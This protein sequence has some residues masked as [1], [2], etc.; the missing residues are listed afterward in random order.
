[1]SHPAQ[2]LPDLRRELATFGVFD[3]LSDEDLLELHSEW[4]SAVAAGVAGSSFGE[5]IAAVL[6]SFEE[7]LSNRITRFTLVMQDVR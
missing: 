3:E 1:M 5:T 6:R 2:I 7:P 4:R